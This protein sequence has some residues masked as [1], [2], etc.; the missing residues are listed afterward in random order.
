MLP[1]GSRQL[2]NYGIKLLERRGFKFEGL[3]ILERDDIVLFEKKYYWVVPSGRLERLPSNV[4]S[5]WCSQVQ[6]T[7]LRTLK[8]RGVYIPPFMRERIKDSIRWKNSKFVHKATKLLEV[9]SH[10]LSA[11]Q[12]LFNFI[13]R[14]GKNL[15]WSTGYHKFGDEHM[16][17]LPKWDRDVW[18]DI[19]ILEIQKMWRGYYRRKATV[20]ALISLMSRRR[21]SLL[22]QW[23]WRYHHGLGMRLMLLQ[24]VSR[25]SMKIN[26]SFLL[27]PYTFYHL[28]R[29]KPVGAHLNVAA[30]Q[31]PE[32]STFSPKKF[33]K[34][35]GPPVWLT[36]G[37]VM[38]LLQQEPRKFFYSLLCDSSI[39]VGIRNVYRKEFSTGKLNLIQFTFPST[40]AARSRA[41]ALMLYSFDHQSRN[42]VCPIDLNEFNSWLRSTGAQSES[43]TYSTISSNFSDIVGNNEAH[44][45]HEFAWIVKKI[46]KWLHQ[47]E[48]FLS[49]QLRLSFMIDC[50]RARGSSKLSDIVSQSVATSTDQMDEKEK[51]PALEYMNAL[52]RQDDLFSDILSQSKSLTTE[53]FSQEHN[54]KL[55]SIMANLPTKHLWN[56]ARVLHWCHEDFSVVTQGCAS[57]SKG[58]KIVEAV[59]TRLEYII[60]GV[61]RVQMELENDILKQQSAAVTQKMKEQEM[62]KRKN[63]F[64]STRAAEYRPCPYQWELPNLNAKERL[65][66]GR[67]QA[68]ALFKRE[69]T[70]T[71]NRSSSKR[72]A[73]GEQGL[74]VETE[75]VRLSEP[76]VYLP[77]PPVT[78]PNHHSPPRTRNRESGGSAPFSAP[79][80]DGRQLSNT[81]PPTGD[82][83][84]TQRRRLAKLRKSV[85]NQKMLHDAKLG[86]N[87]SKK[88]TN[89]VMLSLLKS[90]PT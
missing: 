29:E 60:Q 17:A 55:D 89:K 76:N 72:D 27:D 37:K 39:K 69:K 7:R 36:S 58:S 1:E 2:V 22:L 44:V 47:K 31:F 13:L 43:L 82:E 16:T 86:R 87:E 10:D 49:D 85:H 66:L 83:E 77:S 81:I 14:M 30:K 59:T 40:R 45:Q 84:R 88:K 38:P 20:S 68:T 24:E 50:L 3:K 80:S 63:Y 62:E 8:R 6:F 70:E 34:R 18:H 73:D 64:H 26:R 35:E 4:W 23:S 51:F 41:Q 5:C 79:A 74:E 32:Y 61:S 52:N 48:F 19:A 42:F 56:V 9:K 21:A 78:L 28:I 65:S 11:L 90:L 67:Q 25:V 33:S 75:T 71:S 57:D 54:S 53:H 15:R 12:V 46:P